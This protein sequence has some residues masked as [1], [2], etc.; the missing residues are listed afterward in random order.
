MQ[1]LFKLKDWKDGNKLLFYN[2]WV[3][4][5]GIFRKQ[6]EKGK[7]ALVPKAIIHSLTKRPQ[8]FLEIFRRL[9]FPFS[10]EICDFILHSRASAYRFI[11]LLITNRFCSQSPG[12]GLFFSVNRSV[13]SSPLACI[14]AS[15]HWLTA[16]LD[17]MMVQPMQRLVARTDTTPPHPP[18]PSLP[19][20]SVSMVKDLYKSWRI[21][22]Q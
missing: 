1:L 8:K 9:H 19:S 3:A 22:F 10:R 12:P 15:I 18:I 2:R 6:K 11:Y 21:R 17:L 20:T 4:L 5:L 14:S 13:K 16:C 7:S